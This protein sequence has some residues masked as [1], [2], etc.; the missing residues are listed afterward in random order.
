MANAIAGLDLHGLSHEP[1]LRRHLD[2]ICVNNH[3][4]RCL[5]D[6]CFGT[7]EFVFMRISPLLEHFPVLAQYVSYIPD[8]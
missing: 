6:D 7:Q 4:E 3:L 1:V 8:G 2:E 5:D